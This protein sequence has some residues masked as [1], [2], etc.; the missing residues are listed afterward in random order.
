MLSWAAL[1]ATT[2]VL[3]QLKTKKMIFVT[4]Q[5]ELKYHFIEL[6]M[7]GFYGLP[8]I[9]YVAYCISMFA[10]NIHQ[11]G[12]KNSKLTLTKL[13]LVNILC[14]WGLLP[15]PLDAS[16]GCPWYPWCPWPGSGIPWLCVGRSSNQERSTLELPSALES[17]LLWIRVGLSLVCFLTRMSETGNVDR[18][19]LTGELTN[20][21]FLLFL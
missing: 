12:N 11:L 6:L 1:T 20:F 14:L 16:W 19:E 8:T 21:S 18:L 2:C 7:S 17:L 5:I 9:F 15:P 13:P 10:I 3:L 4:S